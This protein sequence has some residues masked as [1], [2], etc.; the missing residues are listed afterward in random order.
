MSIGV[1]DRLEMVEIDQQQCQCRLPAIV[2]PK[3]AFEEFM[4]G[5]TIHEPG[6]L[7]CG[8]HYLQVVAL[9]AKGEPD[10]AKASAQP[11]DVI[12]QGEKSLYRIG[13]KG[14]GVGIPDGGCDQAAYLQKAE[15]EQDGSQRA[16]RDLEEPGIS[17]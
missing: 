5:A 9:S 14:I 1:V 16:D 3:L 6:K 4:E 2:G 12:E 11:E 13:M 10:Y 15:Q 7:V 8:G 17:A